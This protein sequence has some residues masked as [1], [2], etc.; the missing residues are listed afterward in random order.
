MFSLHRRS[1]FKKK[2]P[3]ATS[4][5]LCVGEHQIV[6]QRKA[7]RRS[8]KLTLRI[9]GTVCV[10][11]PLGMPVAR[12]EAFVLEQNAW[13]RSGASN[14][15]QLRQKHP[16]KRYQEGETFDFLGR[17]YGLRFAESRSDGRGRTC[18]ALS[19]SNSY[20]GQVSELV[21]EIPQNA[22]NAFDRQADH[23]ELAEPLREYY[24][25]LGR[26]FI[27]ER[28]QK[29]SRE[30]GLYPSG[31]SF[32]SQKTRWG[33]CSA[34]GKISLNWRLMVAPLNVVD[35]VVIHELAHLQHLNHSASFWRLVNRHCQQSQ[36]ARVW[37][38]ENQFASD[39]LASRSELHREQ[40]EI[41]MS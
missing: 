16:A 6:V 17:A 41:M 23:P 22:W 18:F 11:A 30:I 29:Y 27:G 3:V 13:I 25:L 36:S 40:S 12:I 9:D 32:R 15:R 33:S 4:E 37:L 34:K 10:V 31:V 19:T 39:F 1:F 8:M 35:Y 20:E 28:V 2:R 14:Y 38:K 26:K 7:Y 21:C 5:H 24:A